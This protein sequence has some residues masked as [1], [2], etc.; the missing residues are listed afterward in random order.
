MCLRNRAER[1][2]RLAQ[3]FLVYVCRRGR[4]GGDKGICQGAYCTD[5]IQLIVMY[6][7]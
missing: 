7:A 4:A 2:S 1:E 3:T 5:A 6:S